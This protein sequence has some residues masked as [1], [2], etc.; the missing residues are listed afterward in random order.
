MRFLLFGTLCGLLTACQPEVRIACVGDSITFGDGLQRR[1]HTCYPARLERLLG[2][3]VEVG[4]FG[5]NG[6]S[7]LRN[8][9]WPYWNQPELGAALRFQ[10]HIVVIALGTNGSRTPNRV[11]LDHFV[12]DYLEMVDTFASLPTRPEIFLCKPPPAFSGKWGT[13]PDTLRQLIL[14][15]IDSV[16]L[17]RGL[18]VI[19]FHT[20]LEGRVELFPDSIHPGLEGAAV[21]AQTVAQTL[22]ARSKRL[23]HEG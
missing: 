6:T 7:L 23:P 20:P 13:S 2:K 5:A 15:L 22:R 11:H 12:Q 10:P 1:H 21:L 19:D 4:N 3:G 9:D 8:S 18:P 16:A 17:L 14:P